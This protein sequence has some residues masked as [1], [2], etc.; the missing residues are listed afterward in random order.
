MQANFKFKPGDIIAHAHENPAV[1]YHVTHMP[2]K[3]VVFVAGRGNG[4][5]A[6]LCY[7][8][9]KN[10]LDEPRLGILPGSTRMYPDGP[11]A[12]SDLPD[13]TTECGC[14]WAKE[15]CCPEKCH[16]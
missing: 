3:Y 16:D 4:L 12:G 1:I 15:C 11:A 5:D 10:P 8:V 13:D 14:G 7:S 9:A 6:A 2:N